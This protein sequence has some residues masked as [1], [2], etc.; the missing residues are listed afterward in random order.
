MNIV[1]MGTPDFAVPCLEALVEKGHRI[2]AV[3][4]QPD[5][6]KGRGHKLCPPP[7]KEC[8]LKY[9]IDVFQPEKIKNNPEVEDKLRSLN[10]DLAVVV[11]YGKILPKEILDIPA[12]GCINIHASLLPKY[13]GSAPIQWAVINGEKR[14]GVTSMLLDEGMDTGDILLK[15][16]FEIPDKMTAGELFDSLAPLG[17]ELLTETVDQLE[18]GLVFP[19]KQDEASATHAPMLSREMAALDFSKPAGQI[20]NLIRGLNPWPV[21]YTFAGDMKIKIYSAEISGNTEA[22]PGTVLPGKSLRVACG[23]KKVLELCEVQLLG[24]RRMT[25]E[26][27]LRGHSIPQGTVLK[28][29]EEK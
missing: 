20:R 5:R 3:F 28:S 12:F 29:Q 26:E 23:D 8:A 11:A 27:M 17:A 6:P 2:M 9:G 13:R 16:E 25:G 7:V 15:K 19:K 10:P 14:T 18:S 4:A 1:F 22:A 21:A 24:S